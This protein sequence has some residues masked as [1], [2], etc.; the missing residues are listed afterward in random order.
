MRKCNRGPERSDLSVIPELDLNPDLWGSPL[1]A[2]F[3]QFHP[4]CAFLFGF[5][6]GH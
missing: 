6:E 2:F 3:F 1:Q 4:D 5:Q